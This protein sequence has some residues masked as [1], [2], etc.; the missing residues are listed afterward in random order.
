MQ[1]LQAGGVPCV[2][3][4][5]A[6]EPEQA[7]APDLT[8]QWLRQQQGRAVKILDPQRASCSLSDQHAIAIF[9][10][11]DHNQQAASALKLFRTMFSIVSTGRKQRRAMAAG[12]R[13]DEIDA[14]TALG[15]LDRLDLT[16][17]RL[18]RTPADSAQRL[19]TFLERHG[20][21]LDWVAAA[22]CVLPRS[23]DNL[24]YLLE[25]QLLQETNSRADHQP[26]EGA[27]C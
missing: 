22:R 24:P 3:E 21:A 27:P 4:W 5:P 1:M 23:P 6:F 26:K 8:S 18:I 9:L 19:H 13:R 25:I 11:R 14:R 12:L 17:E 7:N 10:T 20:H 15:L 2:G 16:F